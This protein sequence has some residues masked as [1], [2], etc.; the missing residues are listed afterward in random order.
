MVMVQAEVEILWI[1]FQVS[2]SL[3]DWFHSL[4]AQVELCWLACC[5]VV[6]SVQGIFISA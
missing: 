4:A 3:I 5:K 1:P 6:H 2:S